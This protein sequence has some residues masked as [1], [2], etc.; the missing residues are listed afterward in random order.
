MAEETDA[1]RTKILAI[2]AITSPFVRFANMEAAGS[3][4]LLASTVIA[5][6]WTNSP[7]EAK[8][9]AI[10]NTQLLMGFGQFFLSESRHQWIN[11]GL[12]SVFFFL[13]GLE[14][15][16]EVLI[17]ELS[18]LR[19]G[20][21]ACVRVLG[22]I[23]AAAK[24]PV[25][26]GVALGLFVGNP[27][28]IGLFAWLSAKLNLGTPP[29]E[30]SRRQIFGSS[31]LCG[32]GFTMSLFIASLAFGDGA[33]LEMSIIGILVASGAAGVCG[34]FL[35]VRHDERALS[36]SPSLESSNGKTVELSS[37]AG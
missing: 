15:K 9:H 30:V 20:D 18:S 25:R 13:V 1:S 26:L 28:G 7:W 4:L 19:Q 11:D 2:E 31:W 37:S 8:Y 12:M 35:M 17:G 23:A 29:T 22:N 14:I 3:I 6:V 34:S 5:P 10:R 27:L 33:L 16:R 32:I 24:H 36:A 21:L